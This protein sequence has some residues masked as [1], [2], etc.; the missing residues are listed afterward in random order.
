MTAKPTQRRAAPTKA[1]APAVR[2][3]TEREAADMAAAVQLYRDTR[4]E[5]PKIVGKINSAGG[6][7]LDAPHSNAEGWL[8]Q[9]VTSMG[10]GSE[11]LSNLLRGHLIN[12]RGGGTPKTEEEAQ[13]LA[14][15]LREG[16]AFVDAIGPRS[17]L[18]AIMAVQMFATHC[19]TMKVTRHLHRADTLEQ[20]EAHGKLMSKMARTFSAQAETLQKIRTGGKQQV[21]VRYVYVDARTQTVVNGGGGEPQMLPQGHATGTAAAPLGLPLWCAD[22][23]GDALPVAS[24]EGAEALQ[25]ARGH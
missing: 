25:D 2:E 17:E 22:A 4:R 19:A 8:C 1:K 13:R 16:M 20:L 7:M 6:L 24:R 3:P 18:E 23:G 15:D 14:E 10:T 9:L 12:A 5:P 21:E 11:V